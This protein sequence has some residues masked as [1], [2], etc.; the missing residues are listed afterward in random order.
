MD[1][2]SPSPTTTSAAATSFPSNDA[3]AA[4]PAYTPAQKD[5]IEQ[6][7]MP[8]AERPVFPEDLRTELRAELE[9]ELNSL[10]QHIPDDQQLFVAKRTLGQ[11]M[12]CEDNYLAELEE[13]FAWSIPVARG[14]LSHKAIELSV[15]WPGDR[16]PGVLVDETLAKLQQSDTDLALWFQALDMA[17]EAQLRSDVTNHVAQFLEAWPPLKKQWRPTL[18]SK[19]RVEIAGGKIVLQGKADLAVGR[20]NGDIAGKVIVDF[21]TGSP[22]PVHRDDLRF[23]ALLD[24]VKIGTPPR[25]LA[26]YYLD[27]ARFVPEDVSLELL[28]SAVA[29]VADSVRRLVELRFRDAQPTR[30]PSHACNW[31]PR[32]P[33]CEQGTTYLQTAN[34]LI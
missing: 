3:G 25:R 23:Y 21:K 17:D 13:P 12:A 6:L 30:S 20:A 14:T 33:N 24:A 4:A 1:S 8:M 28:Y 32:Q 22:S 15:Y 19:V 18:E 10:S 16:N 9:I 27:Q 34:E 5:V 7:G 26:S 2:P 29:R 11:I 31:C